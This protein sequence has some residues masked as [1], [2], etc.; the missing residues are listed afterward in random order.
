MGTQLEIITQFTSNSKYY[1][2]KYNKI[3]DTDYGKILNGENVDVVDL[4]NH[5]IHRS[6]D[7]KNGDI[8]FT[9]DLKP[10]TTLKHSSNPIT[11]LNMNLDSA[12]IIEK[13][14]PNIFTWVFNGLNLKAYA[15]IPNSN[16]KIQGTISRYGGCYNFI[17]VIRQHLINIT[18]MNRG[19]SPNFNFFNITEEVEETELS[20]GS[21]NAFT[22]NHSITISLDED[23][24]SIMKRSRYNVQNIVKLNTLDIKFWAR[25]IN[26]D[27]IADAKHI[28]LKHNLPI[29]YKFDIYPPCVKNL[30]AVQHKGNYNRFLLARFL[31]SIHNGQD[32][33]FIYELV[34][35]PDEREHIK[36]GNCST[37][38]GFIKNN[39]K[40]YDCPSCSQMRKYCEKS[41]KLSHPLEDI[42]KILEK[43]K[44]GKND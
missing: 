16:Q 10:K 29:D 40:R 19:I 12:K 24:K 34:M 6:I 13:I 35:S 5:E 22:Q 41:C 1:M 43:K 33:K 7:Y 26:P 18:K 23:Y 39:F 4:Q 31:L 8:L 11:L 3:A 42:Q 20:I 17:K 27:L 9:L 37:Q 44:D 21:I 32:S 28:K 36:V 30:M 25:E 38:W 2:V 15:I 14:Y